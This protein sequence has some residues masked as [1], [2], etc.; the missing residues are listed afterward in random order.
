MREGFPVWYLQEPSEKNEWN[1]KMG[2]WGWNYWAYVANENFHR[3]IAREHPDANACV[4]SNNGVGNVMFMD[5][6]A[7]GVIERIERETKQKFPVTRTVVTRPS[8]SWKRHCYFT[9]TAYSVLRFAELGSVELAGQIRDMSCYK[10]D[11]KGKQVHE[12]LVDIKGIGK[13]GLVVAPGSRR[14]NGEAYTGDTTPVIPIS[15]W[16]VDWIVDALKACRAKDSTEI[17]DNALVNAAQTPEE[18]AARRAA[19][20]PTAFNVPSDKAYFYLM[21]KAKLLARQGLDAPTR[22]VCLDFFAVRDCQDFSKEKLK[23]IAYDKRLVARPFKPED[24]P[25]RKKQKPQESQ[26]PAMIITKKQRATIHQIFTGEVSLFPTEITSAETRSRFT[27]AAKTAG[28]DI[29]WNSKD[30]SI[31]SEVLRTAGYSL[32]NGGRMWVKS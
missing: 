18:V 11:K 15:D 6:D 28:R 23:T 25:K 26:E 1:E 13:G 30:R 21:S 16:L 31:A 5:F 14:L 19:G 24:I 12:N 10:P 8:A 3:L 20:D 17:V 32:A 7:D 4:I 2:G 29:G 27:A 9:Q 22:L